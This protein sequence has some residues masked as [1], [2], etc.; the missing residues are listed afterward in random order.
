MQDLKPFELGVMFNANNG[1]S[2]TGPK[3]HLP[4]HLGTDAPA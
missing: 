4:D 2:G 1:V 3:K